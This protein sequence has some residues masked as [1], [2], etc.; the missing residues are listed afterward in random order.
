[1]IHYIAKDSLF[2]DYIFSLSYYLILQ[3]DGDISDI[4][5]SYKYSVVDTEF[6]S[7]SKVAGAFERK[8]KILYEMAQNYISDINE[9]YGILN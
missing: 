4:P 2:D 7:N 8:W 9:L 6:N 3:V 5:L 1:M